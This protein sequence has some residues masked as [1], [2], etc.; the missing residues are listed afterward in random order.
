MLLTLT[1]TQ[2]TS[3]VSYSGGTRFETPPRMHT[4]INVL[5]S[6]PQSFEPSHLA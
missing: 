2:V 5:C 4:L 3:L 6:I 1:T